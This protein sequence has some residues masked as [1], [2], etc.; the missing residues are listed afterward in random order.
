MG[1]ADSFSP[2]TAKTLLGHSYEVKTVIPHRNNV[3]TVNLKPC[4]L[5]IPCAFYIDTWLFREHAQ[6]ALCYGTPT[7]DINHCRNEPVHPCKWQIAWPILQCLNWSMLHSTDQMA[8][9]R[10]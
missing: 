7:H 4:K 8:L 5:S 9:N 3:N 10:F 6:V 2:L 1:P